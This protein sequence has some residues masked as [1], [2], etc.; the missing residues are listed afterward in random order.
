MTRIEFAPKVSEDFERIIAHREKL[1]A[2]HIQARMD[3]IIQAI[4][5]LEKNPK[6]G[7]PARGEMRELIIGRDAQGYVALYQYIPEIDIAF[8]LAIRSQREAGYRSV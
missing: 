8:V 1:E 6:V 2:Q 7:R 5:T 3:E 4:A